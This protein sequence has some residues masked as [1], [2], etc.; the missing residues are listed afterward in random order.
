ML[1]IELNVNI[2]CELE[3]NIRVVLLVK[4]NSGTP[5]VKNRAYPKP[6]LPS[7]GVEV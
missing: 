5:R 3:M 2:I 7:S 1:N 4:T 6:T